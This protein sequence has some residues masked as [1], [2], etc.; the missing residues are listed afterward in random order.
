MAGFFNDKNVEGLMTGDYFCPVCG[1]KMIFEDDETRDILVCEHCGHSMDLD[2]Y[3]FTDEEY[4]K[5]YP[6]KEELDD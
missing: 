5:L 2:H 1:E 3:G 6:T 4:A